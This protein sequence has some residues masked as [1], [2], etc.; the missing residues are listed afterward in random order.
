[1]K[2]VVVG[3]GR[4]KKRERLKTVLTN[5][6]ACKE[7][8]EIIIPMKPGAAAYAYDWAAEAEHVIPTTQVPLKE[9]S[10]RG[11]ILRNLEIIKMNP[12]AILVANTDFY[13]DHLIDAAHKAKIQVL[14]VE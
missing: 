6:H 1:M 2:L 14:Y 4:F 13:I 11:E 3:T 10:A 5:I 8:K 9:Q 7:L 12:D